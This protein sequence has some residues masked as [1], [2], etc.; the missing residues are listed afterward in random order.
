MM[1]AI[2]TSVQLFAEVFELGR[3]GRNGL[4]HA[5]GRWE[6]GAACPDPAEDDRWFP[7]PAGSR[8][9]P[10]RAVSW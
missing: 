5:R 7:G 3:S 6:L 1:R 8:K 9:L 2:D 4:A 10:P